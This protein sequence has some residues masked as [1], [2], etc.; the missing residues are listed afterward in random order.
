MFDLLGTNCA[1]G[2]SCFT[3][4]KATV[5][6]NVVF[7]REV[8]MQEGKEGQRVLLGLLRR[9]FESAVA[10]NAITTW[11]WYVASELL[12]SGLG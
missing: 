11:L 5:L 9:K 1:V 2:A 6:V 3:V 8:C 4:Y 7:D 12:G 10:L